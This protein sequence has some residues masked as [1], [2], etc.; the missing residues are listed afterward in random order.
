[1]PKPQTSHCAIQQP[2]E[3]RWIW[4]IS[5]KHLRGREAQG[6]P[7]HHHSFRKGK[8]SGIFI[9]FGEKEIKAVKLL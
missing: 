8:A 4:D 2:G 1:M 6:P 7:N 5:T 9:A 3:L